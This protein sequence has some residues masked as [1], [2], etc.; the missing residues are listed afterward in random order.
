VKELVD[1]VSRFGA[2]EN[3]LHE[4]LDELGKPRTKETRRFDYLVAISESPPGVLEIQEYRTRR[5]GIDDFPN[6][7]GTYGL[8]GLAFIFHPDVRDDFESRN[9]LC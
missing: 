9:H 5:A 7:I 1:N 4:D 6:H 3:L 2:T 8:P